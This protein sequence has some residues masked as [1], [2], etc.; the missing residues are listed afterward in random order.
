MGFS[1][2]VI[3]GATPYSCVTTR[4][5]VSG[6]PRAPRSP[7]ALAVSSAAKHAPA[8]ACTAVTPP[9]GRWSTSSGCLGAP[10]CGV[11]VSDGGDEHDPSKPCAAALPRSRI[12]GSERAL[13]RHSCGWSSAGKMACPAA[14][15]GCIARWSGDGDFRRPI[16]RAGASEAWLCCDNGR[17]CS[18]SC[19]DS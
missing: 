11:R 6:P 5:L 13:A 3:S 12:G 1:G 14:R 19:C 2:A 18:D 9:C 4:Q 10:T 17:I 16:L 7:H 8:W 15:S